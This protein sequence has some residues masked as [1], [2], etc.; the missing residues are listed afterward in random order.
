MAVFPPVEGLCVSSTYV[1][2]CLRISWSPSDFNCDGVVASPV[3]GISG[4]NVY[5]GLSQYSPFS[6]LTTSPIA[7]L[8]YFYTPP[9]SIGWRRNENVRNEYWFSIAAVG[10]IGEG[11]R[12]APRTFRP[13]WAFD[14]APIDGMCN[15]VYL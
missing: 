10:A 15:G 12:C 3:D 4:Y 11:A 6:L 7:G 13:Y 9:E 2:L 1:G 5:R 8:T 14:E